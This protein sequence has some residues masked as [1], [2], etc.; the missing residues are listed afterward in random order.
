MFSSSLNFLRVRVLIDP[1][2]PLLRR[3]RIPLSNG[4]D[5]WVEVIYERIF[6]QCRFCRILGHTMPECPRSVDDVL[7]GFNYVHHRLDDLFRGHIRGSFDHGPSVNIWF[8]WIRRN[9]TRGTTRI[10]FLQGPSI[11]RTFETK[12]ED[13]ILLEMSNLLLFLISLTQTLLIQTPLGLIMRMVL[14]NQ[15]PTEILHL[16]FLLQILH[17]PPLT[18]TPW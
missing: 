13:I 3:I 9:R 14:T 11:Y 12:P 7:S 8:N 2:L 5:A 18:W 15:F 10:V 17:H 16:L 1:R 6:R 4:E